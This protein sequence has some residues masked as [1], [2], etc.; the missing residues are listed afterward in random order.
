ME[1]P[2]EGLT[3]VQLQGAV[4]RCSCKVLCKDASRSDL[5]QNLRQTFQRNL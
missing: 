3:K 5:S 4:A 1:G 2:V